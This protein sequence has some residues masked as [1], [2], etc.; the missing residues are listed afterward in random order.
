MTEVA[1]LPLG[2][3]LILAAI[4]A[5]AL[6]IFA[7]RSRTGRW[8]LAAVL[9]AVLA[10]VAV[11]FI[12]FRQS[13]H[14][15]VAVQ[16]ASPDWPTTNPASLTPW[17]PEAS[18]DFLADTYPSIP[19][20]AEALGKSML[21]KAAERSDMQ[22]LTV[23][24]SGNV[25]NDALARVCKALQQ[26]NLAEQAYLATEDPSSRPADD[27]DTK[28]VRLKMEVKVGR[29]SYG[30]VWAELKSRH[31]NS[32]SSVPFVNKPW[33]DDFTSFQSANPDKQWILVGADKPYSTSDEAMHA[34]IAMAAGRLAS[35]FRAVVPATTAGRLAR[36]YGE[37][38]PVR[39]LAEKI[40]NGEL[41]HDLSLIHI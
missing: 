5:V 13:V 7:L 25:G 3:L 34:A 1:I 21:A 9:V 32:T 29:G 4:A 18:A 30:D 15:P 26:A 22:S 28:L 40:R 38:W 39:L 6:A 37:N 2:L 31:Y 17:T 16:Y 11:S 24:V 10:L 19:A 14:R 8:V 20:A 41:V 33:L 23:E 12:G 36:R 27:A 35:Q